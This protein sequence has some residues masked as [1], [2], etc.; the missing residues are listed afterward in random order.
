MG[1][2]KVDAVVR[3]PVVITIN[4]ARA[5]K[6]AS[7]ERHFRVFW[8]GLRCFRV[9][10]GQ[11]GHQPKILGG[12]RSR[13]KVEKMWSTLKR[14]SIRGERKVARRGHRWSQT[15]T[16]VSDGHP[17]QGCARGV[18]FVPQGRVSRS[19]RGL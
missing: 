19:H 13:Y 14:W 3:F 15:G 8:G 5:R 10:Q 12:P 9:Y 6:P 7:R 11:G 16:A 1:C 18:G 2:E 4:V 17:N